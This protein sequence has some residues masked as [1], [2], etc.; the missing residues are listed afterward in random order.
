[1]GASR[2]PSTSIAMI[3]AILAVLIAI[4]P[5]LNGGATSAELADLDKAIFVL[6]TEIQAEQELRAAEIVNNQKQTVEVPA[7]KASAPKVDQDKKFL[8]C[9]KKA[10][11]LPLSDRAEYIE[12][13]CLGV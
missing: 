8:E 6:H 5:V 4:G 11:R 7:P 12:T 1:M 10:K 9:K 2:E 13:R 3:E